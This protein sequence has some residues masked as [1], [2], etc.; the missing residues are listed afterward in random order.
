MVISS[1]VK[2]NGTPAAMFF[3]SIMPAWC[4][5]EYTNKFGDLVMYDRDIVER[6][7]YNF[8]VLKY[9]LRISLNPFHLLKHKRNIL[10][11]YN[12]I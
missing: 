7:K 4:V 3:Y 2:G 6:R 10:G 12:L 11:F 9:Y 5:L 1:G 8:N